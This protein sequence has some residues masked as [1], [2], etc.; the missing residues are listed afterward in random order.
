MEFGSE[1]FYFFDFDT[2]QPKEG[3]TWFIVRPA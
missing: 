2:P 1:I 3:D